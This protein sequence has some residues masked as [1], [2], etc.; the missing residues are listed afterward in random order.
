M[1][2]GN[3]VR[4][5]NDRNETKPTVDGDNSAKKDR[6]VGDAL[7]AVYREAVAEDVPDEML[8]LLKKLG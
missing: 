6:N 1:G 8:D 5:D 2:K 7:R 3:T 4:S